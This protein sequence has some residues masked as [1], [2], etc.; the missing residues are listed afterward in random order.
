MI[1]IIDCSSY[2]AT[3][4]V[5]EKYIWTQSPLKVNAKTSTRGFFHLQY[6]FEGEREHKVVWSESWFKG[7]YVRLQPF[8]TCCTP[9]QIY[10]TGI[11][12]TPNG[13]FSAHPLPPPPCTA[14]PPPLQGKWT[15]AFVQT[16]GPMRANNSQQTWHKSSLRH[17][18]IS[19]MLAMGQWVARGHVTDLQVAFPQQR[20]GG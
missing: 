11:R 20:G 7:T 17:T 2:R 10:V 16:Q 18:W 14:P 1:S 19:L 9:R 13:A 15:F 3:D 5:N 4:S 8:L 6:S 12:K